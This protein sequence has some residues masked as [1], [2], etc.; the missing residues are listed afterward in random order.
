[1]ASLEACLIPQ[2]M[3]ITH[4]AYLQDKKLGFVIK[5]CALSFKYLSI[6]LILKWRT[7]KAKGP[8]TDPVL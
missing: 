4:A 2:I 5:K 7:L 8:A 3:A 1:M 6:E